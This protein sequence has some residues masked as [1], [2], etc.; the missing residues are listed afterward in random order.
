M[1]GGVDGQVR[2]GVEERS[3]AEDGGRRKRAVRKGRGGDIC[4][5]LPRTSVSPVGK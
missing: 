2:I 4:I 3:S 1:L 5:R